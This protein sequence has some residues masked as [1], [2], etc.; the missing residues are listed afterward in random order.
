MD[1][2]IK[3]IRY[4]IRGLRKHPGFAAIAIITLALGIGANTAIFSVVNAV[5]LRPLPFKD[6]GGLVMVW[7][8][9]VEA[10]G[11]DRTPLAYAD[12]L[13]W[14]AQS[15]SF[16]SIGAFQ[17]AQFN[18]SGSAVPEQVPGANVTANFLS[19]LGVPVQLGRDLSAEDERPGTTQAVLISD[20][21]WR[22]NFN[23]DRNVIGRSVT[24]SGSSAIIVGVTPPHFD[25]PHREVDIWSALQLD[26]PARRGPYFLRGI[27]RL[28]PGVSIAQAVADTG[29]ITSSFDKGNFKFNIISVNDFI[30]GEVRLALTAL[31]IA[32]TLVLLIA[33]VN[34]ANLTLVRAESRIKEFSIR[35]ALGASRSR[36]IAQSLTE[37][38]ILALVGGALALLL[39][40]VVVELVLKLAP[41][42]LPRLEQVGIDG[43]VLGWTAAISILSGLIF[44]LAPAWQSSRFDLNESLKEGGRSSTQAA[45]KQ[46]WRKMLVVSELAL[47]VILVSGAG[48]LVKSLWR[49]QQVP[50]GVNSDHVLTMQVM[51]RGQQYEEE[52]NVRS[53]YLRMLDQVKNLPGVR[54]VAIT[55]SIPPDST[56]YSSNFAIEGHPRGEGPDQRVAF[57]VHVSPDYFRALDIP[58]KEG[59]LFT[60]SDTP[61]APK[62]LLINETLERRF[63][64]GEEPIGK[65]VNIGGETEPHWLQVVGVVADVK[66]NGVAEGVQPAIYLPQTQTPSS[67]AALIIKS[68]IEN[69]L[70]LTA[71]VRNELKKIDPEL[72]IAEVKTLDDRITLSMAQPRFRTT[73]IALFAIV[74]LILACIG[75]Y[76][77]ISYSVSQ[78]TH[79]IGVRMA[80]GAQ[81]TDVL[82]L[83]I[84]QG[85]WLAAIGVGVGLAASLALTR[86]INSLLFEVKATDFS[87]FA[88]TVMLLALTALMACYLPARRASKVDP[89]VALRHE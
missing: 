4:S 13:D 37:S 56:D 8:R 88:T 87:T 35:S 60:D 72:P 31:L 6:P 69:P 14:R 82:S 50:L 63:F 49:L 52:N 3:D 17:Y 67:G 28:K 61:T 24:L 58:L 21:F 51:L 2:L 59:R 34:V 44:G 23:A 70:S 78:R 32:V 22:R 18:Y 43:R 39:A 46:R 16:E 5:L 10:A 85:L 57:F 55:N 38:L 1:S 25:F 29:A 79:E 41:E 19:V 53:F 40:N 65:R 89:L 74:A 83:V 71:S 27:A 73:L 36:I 30:V 66:Y 76:G 15:R 81:A 80:L 62:V 86:L 75:V 9:G 45:S 11:G 47:A 84:K 26:H 33:T 7:H 12:L 54:A 77:V 68:D 20:R 42:G 48:L 64:S